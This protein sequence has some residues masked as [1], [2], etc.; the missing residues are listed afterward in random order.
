MALTAKQLQARE[1][2][3]TASSVG[4]LMRGDAEKIY[5]LWLECI[6]DPAWVAPNFD[7]NWAV[8]MGNITE[9][10]NL[11]WYEK[12]YGKVTRQGEVVTMV[13]PAWAACTLDGFDAERRIPI[14]CKF[15]LYKKPDEVR[16]WYM[17]Q[18]HWQMAVTG[19]RQCAISVITGGNEPRVE[20]VDYSDAYAGELW[21][22][23][24]EFWHCVE[25]LTPPVTLEAIKPPVPKEQWRTVSMEGNNGWASAAADWLENK[26]SAK[27]FDQAKDEIKE[28]VEPDVGVAT[29]HGIIVKRSVSGSLTIKQEK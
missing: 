3:L 17:P 19:T 4:V 29:G 9:P 6:G 22:R 14:E 18:L 7:D 1:G 24:T 28:L 23:A 20:Y 26:E 10:L 21:K 16:D 2:K 13:T 25:T 12:K 27:K 11:A 8:Q 5:N 15:S